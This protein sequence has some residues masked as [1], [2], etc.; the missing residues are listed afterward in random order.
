MEAAENLAVGE[1]IAVAGAAESGPEGGGDEDDLG[2]AGQNVGGFIEH[3]GVYDGFFV[4]FDEVV[5]PFCD[6]WVNHGFLNGEELRE[7]KKELA[8]GA[9]VYAA[10]FSFEFKM[11]LL[12]IGNKGVQN[13]VFYKFYC[14]V[15][16][17][18]GVYGRPAFFF[19]L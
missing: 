10:V 18:V 1:V 11:L 9:A 17:E 3:G 14:V 8:E 16:Q 12:G 4:A 19:H 5:Y 6:D 15:N 2:A 7:G 13:S